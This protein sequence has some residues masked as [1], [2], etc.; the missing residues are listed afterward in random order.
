MS[1]DLVVHFE[2]TAYRRFTAASW[3]VRSFTN[4]FSENGDEAALR[5]LI[6]RAAHE[7]RRYRRWLRYRFAVMAAP[8]PHAVT[9][10]EIASGAYGQG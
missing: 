2:R 10:V 1:P 4:T 7:E 6:A 5:S 9:P 3:A 8:G